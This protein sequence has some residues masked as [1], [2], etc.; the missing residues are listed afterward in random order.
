MA[1]LG[2]VLLP[3]AN[4]AAPAAKPN[5]VWD[6][7]TGQVALSNDRLQLIIETKPGLNARLLRDLKSGQ[8]YADRDYSWPGGAFPKLIATPMIRKLANGSRSATFRGRLNDVEIVQVFTAPADQPGA[9]IERIAIHNPGN[10][11]LPAAK[12]KCG[13]TKCIRQ[14]EAWLPDASDIQLC[15]I[16]YRR[17]TNGKMQEVPL[18]TV[19]ERESS[20]SGWAEPVYPTPIWGAEGWVWNKQAASLLIAKHNPNNME[21]SLLEPL[22]R[23]METVVRFGGAGQWKHGNPEGSTRIDP[24]KS[25]QFGETRLQVVEGDWKQ[26]YYAYRGWMESKGCQI[27][28]GYNPPVHWNEL[29]DNEYFFKVGALLDDRKVWYTPEFDAQN[30]TLLS[31]FYSRNLM[32]AEAAKAADF[33]CGA[34]YLDPGWDT[35]PSHHLWDVPRLGSMRSFVRSMNHDYHLR[36]SLWI[37]LAGVPPTYADP[38]SCPPEAQVMNKDGKSTPVHCFASPAFLDTKAQR[39]LDLC[40]HGIA[41]IM[42]DSTQYS[43]PCYDKAH[44]HQ[45]PSTRE[46]HARALFELVRRI[47]NKYPHVLIEIHDPITGPSGIHYTPTYFGYAPPRSFDCLWGHEFMWNP[48]DDLLSR[49]AVSLYY[50]NLAYSIPLYLHVNLKG[51]NENALIFWWYASMCRHLGVGGKPPEAVW[52][53]EKTAMQA[54]NSLKQFYSQGI[55]YGLDE[56]THAH[57]LSN[58]QE[59]II[60]AFNLEDKPVQKP[61]RFR[62]GEIGLPSGNVQVVGASFQQNGDE[63]SLTLNLPARGHQLLKVRHAATRTRR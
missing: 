5:V 41:F 57:T 1:V 14:S 63:I 7:E 6:P 3:I 61:V 32:L 30:K 27:P 56:M 17:E 25:Y 2:V 35:G 55:F 58:L 39:L 37:G 42:F 20:F 36:V 18:R 21:W 23:G 47:K 26:A 13:F 40:R 16:P 12:F 22:K 44:G 45:I 54:Y 24:G 52:E 15:P 29:Y 51:D 48:M 4:A 9:I 38:Q 11:P 33:G 46:E 10:S 50:F 34:L 53:T 19:A 31:Q 60:N 8:A 28:K 62:L 43:G 49:R 59:S